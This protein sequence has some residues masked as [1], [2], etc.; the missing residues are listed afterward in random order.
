MPQAVST[1]TV[2][3]LSAIDQSIKDLV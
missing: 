1:D 2:E 3:C